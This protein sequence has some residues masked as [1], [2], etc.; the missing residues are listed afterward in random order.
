VRGRRVSKPRIMLAP[1][2][3]RKARGCRTLHPPLMPA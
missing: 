1:R 3:L 2:R